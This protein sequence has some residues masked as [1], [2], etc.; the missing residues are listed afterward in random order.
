MTRA[1]HINQPFTVQDGDTIVNSNL[2]NRDIPAIRLHFVGCNLMNCVLVDGLHTHEGCLVGVSQP[3]EEQP[4]TYPELA[5]GAE[6]VLNAL[7]G[8]GKLT[9]EQ[10]TGLE[11]LAAMVKSIAGTD[12]EI[13]ELA[14]QET[15]KML[16]TLRSLGHNDFAD[17]I[18]ATLQQIQAGWEVA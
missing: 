14:T 9:A 15:L 8:S 6:I 1:I 17:M 10:I 18:E 5:A 3:I 13:G 4:Q 2:V 12:A 16:D 11:Q 7:R